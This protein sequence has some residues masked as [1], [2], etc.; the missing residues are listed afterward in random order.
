MK[1]FTAE[2]FKKKYGNVF[3]EKP[4]QGG[5]GADISSAF[6]G[7][8]DYAKEGYEQARSA[9]TPIGKTEGGLKELSG[10]AQAV[11]SPLA[12]VT[13]YIGQ[14]INAAADKI[15]DIPAV[16]DFAMSG[17]GK[18]TARVAE[19]VQNTAGLVGTLEGGIR[20]PSVAKSAG[21]VIGDTSKGAVDA[22]GKSTEKLRTNVKSAAK[23]VIGTS[24]NYIN[25]NIATALNLTPDDLAR[26]EAKTN[27][28]VGTWMADH[29][30]I[31][32]NA[33]TTQQLVNNFKDANYQAVRAEVSRVPTQYKQYQVPRYVETLKQI[34]SKLEDV[35]G[36]EQEWLEVQRLLDKGIERKG[37][38]YEPISLKDVQHAKELVDEHFKLYNAVGDVDA[39]V[40]KS[41][42][43]NMRSALQ[44]FIEQEVK[45]NGGEDI[46]QMNKNVMT[47]RSLSDAITKREPKGLTKSM[48][49][50]GDLATLGYG[51]FAGG[52]AVGLAALFIKKLYD[53][54][55]IQLRIAKKIDEMS[56]AR[57]AKTAK[58]LQEG[59][60]PNEFK[61]EVI[62]K[63]KGQ[64]LN[65]E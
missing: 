47:A 8:V 1:T 41:G 37:A 48:F 31:G 55:T 45:A 52:P 64:R 36:L 43:A 53:S 63:Y 4:Q 13:K 30:L 19:D 2:E 46:A 33:K 59:T 12:P 23:D 20:A 32:E 15:S 17:A 21:K 11:F 42:I 39:S 35:P 16:Q 51:S 40:T 22:V 3:A 5:I 26:I 65:P 62:I 54:P 10:V 50:Q 28:N 9:K 29:N 60:I 7:G 38:G 56:D 61:Q 49:R 14:G 18:T 6:Q 24:Q 58:E 34:K 44:E 25:H 27:N 57:K